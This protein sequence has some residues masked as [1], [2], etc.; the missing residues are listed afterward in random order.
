MASPLARLVAARWT[1]NASQKPRCVRR[2]MTDSEFVLVHV[3]G[4]S[5][6]V[7]VQPTEVRP[8][9]GKFMDIG[10][11]NSYDRLFVCRKDLLQDKD[12]VSQ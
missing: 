6:G 8:P 9:D 11:P 10:I 12:F 2:A 3:W 7:A 1:A 5:S 4:D